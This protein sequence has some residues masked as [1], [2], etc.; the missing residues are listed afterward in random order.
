MELIPEEGAGVFAKSISH[1]TLWNNSR[2]LA[3]FH[4]RAVSV[5]HVK[6]LEGVQATHILKYCLKLFS[7]KYVLLFYSFHTL[8]GDRPELKIR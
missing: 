2:V 8:I 7:T 3:R 5:E 4:G 1:Y 6:A